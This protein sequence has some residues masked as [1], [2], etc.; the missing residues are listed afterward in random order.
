[1]SVRRRKRPVALASIAA[2]AAITA[3]AAIASVAIAAGS[4]PVHEQRAATPLDVVRLTAISDLAVAPNG[5]DA[6]FMADAL[7]PDG[8]TRNQRLWRVQLHAPW[9][10]RPLTQKPDDRQAA[11]SPDGRLIAF[12][13]ARA[14]CVRYLPRL[15]KVVRTELSRQFPVASRAFRGR[16][17][18]A[19][20]WLRPPI[21]SASREWRRCRMSISSR[22]PIITT[23]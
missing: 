21:R 22:G 23:F 11:W 17:T 20:S 6:I 16:R 15:R 13:A 2:I 8:R 9:R 7:S 12:C 14:A 10:V 18:R 5:R 1:M 19:A 4:P 3:I